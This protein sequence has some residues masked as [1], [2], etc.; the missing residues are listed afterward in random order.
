MDMR[1]FWLMSFKLQIEINLFREWSKIG[2]KG[3]LSTPFEKFSM[4]FMIAVS[5]KHIYGV[6]GNNYTND[7]NIFLLFLSKVSQLIINTTQR[8]NSRWCYIMNNTSI[9]KTKQVQEF[10]VKNSL[11]IITIPPSCPSLN[12]AETVI[13]SIKSKLNVWLE[14]ESK[15]NLNNRSKLYRL[16][17]LSLI[18]K[19]LREIEND[20]L[21]K[22]YQSSKKSDLTGFKI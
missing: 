10:T 20:G 12:A 2:V 21:R 8:D 7:A 11:N 1:L 9:H 4:N 19:V 5:E 15:L 22:V 3:L 13:Q 17:S 16:L 18:S 6:M 14:M